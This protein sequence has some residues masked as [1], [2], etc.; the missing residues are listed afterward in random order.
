MALITSQEIKT[1][2]SM[3]GNVD[4][5]K[6][7]H[8][9]NDVQVLI[10]EP[11]LGTALY[12]V[13]VAGGLSGEYQTLLD[14]YIKPILIA[15]DGWALFISTPR[16]KNH[17]YK[18]WQTAQSNPPDGIGGCSRAATVKERAGRGRQVAASAMG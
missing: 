13:I 7:M 5:D 10:L 4:A 12:D 17:L 1:N 6:Y 9:L 3:G 15:N 11:A 14:D 18:L 8:L 2:T 16:G